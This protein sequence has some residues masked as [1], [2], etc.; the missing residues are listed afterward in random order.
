MYTISLEICY[1]RCELE[2][3]ELIR[4]I[5]TKHHEYGHRLKA[6]VQD[7]S[8]FGEREGILRPHSIDRTQHE[9]SRSLLVDILTKDGLLTCH[10]KNLTRI[11][12]DS[13]E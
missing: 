2:P 4:W 13:E 12:I 10:C 3:W 9:Q 8:F 11:W 5:V 6:S 7:I 1:C